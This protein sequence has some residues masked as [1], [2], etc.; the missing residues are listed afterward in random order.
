MSANIYWL[1]IDPREPNDVATHTP[2]H[3]QAMLTEAIGPLPL[4]LDFTHLGVL[5]GLR[6]AGVQGIEDLIEAIEKEG[7]IKVWSES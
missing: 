6:V 1:A 4:Q 5:L 7:R 2:S 3:T